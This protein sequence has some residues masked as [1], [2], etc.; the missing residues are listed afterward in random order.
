MGGQRVLLAYNFTPYDQRSL[1]F[2]ARTFLDAGDVEI[3]LFNAYTPVPELDSRETQVLDRMRGNLSYLYQKIQEQKAA[4][5][6]AAEAL[7]DRGF[8][9][10]QVHWVYRPRQKDVASEIVEYAREERYDI[11]IVNHKPG[12]ITRLF[13]GNVFNKVVCALQ[14]ITVCVVL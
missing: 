5:Q 4:I 14:D 11:V 7:R 13:T 2:A 1:D 8:R 6:K 12:R 9:P 10:G 3:T